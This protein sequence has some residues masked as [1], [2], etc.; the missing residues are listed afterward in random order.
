MPTETLA[1]LPWAATL[2][3]HPGPLAADMDYDGA[4]FDGLDLDGPRGAS[5]RFMECAFTRVTIQDGRFRLARFNDVWLSNVRL[6]ATELT[7]NVP[8][9]TRSCLAV[10]PP[11]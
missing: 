2:S 10:W 6:T 5:S 11:G 1:D 9:P 4:H 7:E 3:P 8:G